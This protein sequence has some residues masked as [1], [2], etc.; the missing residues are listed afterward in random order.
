M[1]MLLLLSGPSAGSGYEIAGETGLC[2]SPKCEIALSYAKDS[3]LH[4]RIRLVGGE[5]WIADIGSRNGTR[6]NGERISG[7]VS[8]SAGDRVE[9]GGTTARFEVGFEDLAA[10]DPQDLCIRKVDDLLPPQAAAASMYAVAAALA[11]ARSTAERLRRALEELA[12]R[13]GATRAAAC[14]G[15]PGGLTAPAPIGA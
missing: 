8:L 13:I 11:G 3:R 9:L 10:S 12:Q 1:P 2:R 7:E 4:D 15:A 5:A 6:V 14:L